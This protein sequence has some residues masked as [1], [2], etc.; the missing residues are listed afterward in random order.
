MHHITATNFKDIFTFS[1]DEVRGEFY[2]EKKDSEDYDDDDTKTTRVQAAHSR[3]KCLKKSIMHLLLKI[4]K[5]TVSLTLEKQE[6]IIL[7]ATNNKHT[8][9]INCKNQNTNSKFLQTGIKSIIF[10]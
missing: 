5:D 10:I 8:I 1:D 4:N 3:S 6:L 2:K 7:T 9:E